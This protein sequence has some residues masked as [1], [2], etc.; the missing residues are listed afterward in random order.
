MRPSPL[1]TVDHTT[2]RT[3]GEWE[4]RGVAVA[5]TRF[6]FR[7]GI[8][9]VVPWLVVSDCDNVRPCRACIWTPSWVS[10]ECV[11]FQEPPPSGEFL[12]GE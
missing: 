12:W 11:N 5:G 4:V 9:S 8:A 2:M 10:D 3:F 1:Y 7:T 6:H